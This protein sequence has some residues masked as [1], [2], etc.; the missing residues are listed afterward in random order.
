MRSRFDGIEIG[1]SVDL[2]SSIDGSQAYIGCALEGVHDGDHDIFFGRVLSC[3]QGAG[4]PLTFFWGGFGHSV[5]EPVL[6]TVI[7]AGSR[8]TESCG[9]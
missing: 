5:H 8:S 4:A 7:D 9:T 3:S 2:G 1:K 6:M